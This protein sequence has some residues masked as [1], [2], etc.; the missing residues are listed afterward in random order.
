MANVEVL[1]QCGPNLGRPQVGY[2]QRIDLFQHEGTEDSILR[3]SLAASLSLLL[4][5]ADETRSCWTV[6]TRP[7]KKIILRCSHPDRWSKDFAA[8][9]RTW[10]L[11]EE[12]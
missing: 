10:K 5:H 6:A 9:F 2:R 8:I 11:V 4:I 3:R 12:G 1:K 7:G